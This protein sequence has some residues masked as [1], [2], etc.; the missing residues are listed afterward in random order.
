[1]VNLMRVVQSLGVMVMLGAG[2]VVA[3]TTTLGDVQKAASAPP[4]ATLTAADLGHPTDADA[5][6][7]A[8][9]AVQRSDVTVS[10]YDADKIVGNPVVLADRVKAPGLAPDGAADLGQPAG[11]AAKV[12]DLAVSARAD[13]RLT[14]YDDD[15]IDGNEPQPL[16]LGDRAKAAS[17]LEAGVDPEALGQPAENAPKAGEVVA[18]VA[19]D[20]VSSIYD[21]D[22]IEGNE[23]PPEPLA[24]RQKL[25]GIAVA[26]LDAAALGTPAADAPKAGDLAVSLAADAGPNIDDNDKILGNPYVQPPLSP[27]AKLPSVLPDPVVDADMG[28]PATDA[29]KSGEAGVSLAAD[30]VPNVDDN[31]KIAG[32]PVVSPP[33]GDRAKLPSDVDMTG[34]DP[35]DLGTPADADA[36][37]IATL[38]AARAADAVTSLY[39]EDKIADND[40]YTDSYDGSSDFDMGPPPELVAQIRALLEDPALRTDI[41]TQA[42]GKVALPDIAPDAAPDTAPD[43]LR[44]AFTGF[45]TALFD[46]PAVRDALA[47]TVAAPFADFGMSPDN[48]GVVV[49]MTAEQLAVFGQD[50]VTAGM[51]RLPPDAQRAALGD[52]L[53][54]A[55]PLPADQ[56]GPF[57]RGEMDA[58]QARQIALTAMA[59]WTPAEVEATL[60]RQAAAIV[61][62]VQDNPPRQSLSSG[63]LDRATEL[64]GRALLAALDA[65]PNGADLIAAYGDPYAADAADLCQVQ[66]IILRTALETP[67][68]D[69]D[70]M[71]R[72]IIQDGAGN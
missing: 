36:A 28:Q 24:E 6:K 63:D 26:G 71:V 47:S 3:Q 37:K 23:P 55:E 16:P 65:L 29:P 64:T 58:G 22:K 12:A 35:A 61:A 33:L 67:G 4:T 51:A 27:R 45:L 42:V 32:N 38:D 11:D 49:R 72:T 20:A 8:T 54:I 14:S 62:E 46:Q 5:P 41:L 2:P 69:G 68:A 43:T 70:L 7:T 10:T 25:P 19:T 30:A 60:I 13:A 48:P 9:A 21:E 44:D 40:T 31:D 52:A 56:C 15:K 1:V 17:V 50:Q 59:T 66:T 39:D 57:L 53:R 18:S 34:V